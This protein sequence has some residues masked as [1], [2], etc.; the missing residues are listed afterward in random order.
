M[1]T[2]SVLFC[3]SLFWGVTRSRWVFGYWRLGTLYRS[4]LQ[5]LS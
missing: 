2:Q 5:R 1:Q 3:S 4:H